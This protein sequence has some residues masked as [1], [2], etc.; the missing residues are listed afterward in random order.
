MS[1]QTCSVRSHALSVV[2]EVG[3][4]LKGSVT[5]LLREVTSNG[6]S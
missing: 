5:E 4:K 3:A 6:K 1:F 2:A